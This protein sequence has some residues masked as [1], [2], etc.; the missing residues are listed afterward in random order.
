MKRTEAKDAVVWSG[1][2]KPDGG[3]WGMARWATARVED[4]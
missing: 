2:A 4:L 1:G 3:R